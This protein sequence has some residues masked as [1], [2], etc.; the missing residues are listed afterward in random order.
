MYAERKLGLSRLRKTITTRRLTEADHFPKARN[1][2][3]EFVQQ[4]Q[5]WIPHT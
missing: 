2:Q 4:L 3:I 1:A 5:F